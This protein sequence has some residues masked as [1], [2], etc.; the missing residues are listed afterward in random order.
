MYRLDFT[1][2]KTEFEVYHLILLPFSIHTIIIHNRKKPFVVEP[3]IKV[4]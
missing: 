1:G 3:K 4:I 2:V